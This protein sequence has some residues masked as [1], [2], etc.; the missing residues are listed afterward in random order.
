MALFKL[1][2]GPSADLPTSGDLLKDGYAFFCTDDGKFVINYKDG[3]DGDGNDI[4]RQKRV[5][6][7]ELDS[8][9]QELENLGLDIEEIKAAMAAQTD[10]DQSDDTAV[11]FIKNKPFYDTRKTIRE[12]ERY[13]VTGT[14]ES[15][16]VVSMR[17]EQLP[18]DAIVKLGYYAWGPNNGD[19]SDIGFYCQSEEEILLKNC[20]KKYLMVDIIL[21]IE[22]GS[23]LYTYTA[24]RSV[25]AVRG[26][27]GY[28]VNEVSVSGI[29]EGELK[30]IDDKYLSDNVVKVEN[31]DT[32]IPED[33]VRKEYIN[34]FSVE[35]VNFGTYTVK[36]SFEI[37]SDEQ[38]IIIAREPFMS[39]DAIDYDKESATYGLRQVKLE[40][41][42]TDIDYRSIEVTPEVVKFNHKASGEA[43]KYGAEYKFNQISYFYETP[44]PEDPYNYS[45]TLEFPKEGG[46]IATE[47]WVQDNI[48][49]LE[50]DIPTNL[51][52]GE[53]KGSLQ[54]VQDQESGVTE[55]YFK[56]TDKNPN[57]TA[58]DNTLTGEIQYGASKEF[59]NAFGGKSAAM[60]KR[61]T[62]EGTTT[63]AK[64]DY[65]HAEGNSSVTLGVN[66][67]AEGVQTVSWGNGSHAEGSNTQALNDYAH[68]EGYYTK[69]QG[70]GAHAEG[71]WTEARSAY[72]HASGYGTIASSVNQMVVGSY[73]D[74]K[75]DSLFEVGNGTTKSRSNAFE[76][77][78]DGRAKVYGI[79]L[80]DN[81]LVTVAFMKQYIKDNFATLLEEYF[82]NNQVTFDGGDAGSHEPIAIVGE[83]TLV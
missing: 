34:E 38:Q 2:R 78:K 46:V 61:S 75:E 17:K 20:P 6:A 66:S 1:F 82:A 76:V 52:N 32:Y 72:S 3:V 25:L 7:S 58:L 67:H 21:S 56:F 50:E 24:D 74:N 42:P 70:Y 53:N 40:Q 18:E 51:A 55:G 22:D 68:A 33:I 37:A 23:P 69:A 57:A 28:A 8:I 12:E 43:I 45:G 16:L 60:G 29:R 77:L 4:I 59:A 49:S 30:Q 14:G 47:K 80:E 73:N 13:I 63:I 54:Q 35:S 11:D 19:V 48:Q 71:G 31:F 64:G 26:D 27:P 15:E 62:A 41:Q 79:P 83:T 10:W 5:N 44:V 81:D 39:L 65:S 9:T 36:D